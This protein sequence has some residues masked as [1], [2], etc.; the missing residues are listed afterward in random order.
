MLQTLKEK[1]TIQSVHGSLEN[2]IDP[3]TQKILDQQFKNH[4]DPKTRELEAKLQSV[5]QSM[6]ASN[7]L[8]RPAKNGSNGNRYRDQTAPPEFHEEL[9]VRQSR[10][11][12]KKAPEK[13]DRSF[14]GELRDRLSGRRGRSQ[15]R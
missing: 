14:F 12:T 10:D 15:K 6:S 9:D 7:T 11:K 1:P 8:E 5:A 2:A 4:N 3:T 13:R